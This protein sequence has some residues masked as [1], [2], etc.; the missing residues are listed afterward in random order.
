MEVCHPVNNSSPGVLVL[1]MGF[2]RR[3]YKVVLEC[4]N[5]IPYE[6]WLLFHVTIE[7]LKPMLDLK[8]AL[9]N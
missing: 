5:N 4:K 2:T 1:E 3:Y 8:E 7:G 6:T 9:P